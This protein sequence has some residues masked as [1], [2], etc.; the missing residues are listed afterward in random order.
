MG[1][2]NKKK[3]VPENE[4]TTA[5]KYITHL[6]NPHHYFL[7]FAFIFYKY[8]ENYYRLVVI[9][10]WKIL[11]DQKYPTLT[12]AQTGFFQGYKSQAFKIQSS[13]IP[14]SWNDSYTPDDDWLNDMLDFIDCKFPLLRFFYGAVRNT[15]DKR[16]IKEYFRRLRLGPKQSR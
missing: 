1:S 5:L 16:C 10:H 4:E 9:R 12:E 2:K 8:K 3:Q 11:L 7:D 6:T 15:R 13:P 14:P